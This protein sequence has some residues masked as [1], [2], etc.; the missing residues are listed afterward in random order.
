MNKMIFIIALIILAVALYVFFKPAP[1]K[2]VV[3]LPQVLEQPTVPP[4]TPSPDMKKVKTEDIVVGTG[5][6][7]VPGKT[8]SVQYKGTLTDGTEFDSSY[9]RNSEPLVFTV[10][11]G[12]M[13][14]GFDFGVQGMK[15]GGTRNITIPPELGY[16][17]RESG[18]IP[19]N[20][21]LIFEVKLEKVE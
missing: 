20:S 2:P 10:A 11:A 1:S 8:V 4:A 7:A 16:G 18:P 15:V 9:S 17:S 13:I 12:Q 19:A 3:D 5:D 6:V 14:P 21:T